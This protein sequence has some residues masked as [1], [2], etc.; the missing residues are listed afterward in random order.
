MTTKKMN[1]TKGRGTPGNRSYGPDVSRQHP[2]DL[3]NM[4]KLHK[5]FVLAAP[6]S[7][8]TPDPSTTPAYRRTRLSAAEHLKT[9]QPKKTM[10][11]TTPPAPSRYALNEHEQNR[12]IE[13]IQ[14]AID[15]AA[16][17]NANKQYVPQFVQERRIFIHPDDRTLDH[18]DCGRD[19]SCTGGL[20]EQGFY[21]LCSIEQFD[22]EPLDDGTSAIDAYMIGADP[23][24][25][26]LDEA[27]E[28]AEERLRE[29]ES[30]ETHA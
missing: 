26:I 2:K 29:L 1:T 19:Q 8:K 23:A 15:W 9:Q 5:A 21:Y 12:L 25:T 4:K 18:Y 11:N 17:D 28:Y 22:V 27:L 7:G 10:T 24:G 14:D 6:K 3:E 30:R 20:E 16:H 13:I